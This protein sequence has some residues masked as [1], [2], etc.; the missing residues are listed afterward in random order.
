MPCQVSGAK[1]KWYSSTQWQTFI[2]E[3]LTAK[4]STNF[5]IYILVDRHWCQRIVWLGVFQL[6]SVIKIQGKESFWDKSAHT[7]LDSFLQE[8]G[9]GGR[10]VLGV[11]ERC[12]RVR[13]IPGGGR[14][15]TARSVREKHRHQWRRTLRS[16][17]WRNWRSLPP[18]RFVLSIP[19]W[20]R[21]GPVASWWE[22]SQSDVALWAEYLFIVSLAVAMFPLIVARFQLGACGRQIVWSGNE[23]HFAVGIK[24]EQWLQQNILRASATTSQ[25]PTSI[26]LCSFHLQGQRVLVVRSAGWCLSWRNYWTGYTPGGTWWWS[27]LRTDLRLWMRHSGDQADSRKRWES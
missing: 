3:F 25:I 15:Q 20:I 5:P 10:C 22:D 1:V 4:W 18:E 13:W 24:F 12:G 21:I 7:V 17:Y 26:N 23:L 8:R 2:T 9:W 14:M 11:C 19:E 6:F 16:L 27:V